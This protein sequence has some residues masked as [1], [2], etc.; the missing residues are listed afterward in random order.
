MSLA[1]ASSWRVPVPANSRIRPCIISM[2]PI[3]AMTM[4]TGLTLARRSGA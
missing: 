1:P 3:E 2:T 4:T